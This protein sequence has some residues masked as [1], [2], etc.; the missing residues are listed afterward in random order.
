M[1]AR[2]PRTSCRSPRRRRTRRADPRQGRPLPDSSHEQLAQLT[3]ALR[4]EG[5]EAAYVVADVSVPED[6]ARAVDLAVTTYGRL[7]AA[8]NNAGIGGDRTPLHLRSD[9][10]YTRS[11]VLF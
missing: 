8:F 6:A 2:S 11:A 3:C 5:A 4:G 7:D 9:D 10:V 1:R